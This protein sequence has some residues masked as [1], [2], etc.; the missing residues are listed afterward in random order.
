MQEASSLQGVAVSTVQVGGGRDFDCC[1]L[2]QGA[3]EAIYEHGALSCHGVRTP[4]ARK[5]IEALL[6][7]FGLPGQSGNAE[8]HVVER[9]E[10]V[11]REVPTQFVGQPVEGGTIQGPVHRGRQW[12]TRKD[13]AALGTQNRATLGGEVAKDLEL[14]GDELLCANA[15]TNEVQRQHQRER[16]E[17]SNARADTLIVE[18]FAHGLRFVPVSYGSLTWDFRGACCG[19]LDSL[20]T[21]EK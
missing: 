17:R 6:N 20:E 16:E 21:L 8:Q 5:G 14:T 13:L 10:L 9:L 4:R 15:R 1:R 11:A 2:R 12:V 19:S 7:D 18:E 3:I